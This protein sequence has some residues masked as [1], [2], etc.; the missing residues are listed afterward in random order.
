MSGKNR[1]PHVGFHMPADLRKLMRQVADEQEITVTELMIR[2][3]R[4]YLLN[5]GKIKQ[6]DLK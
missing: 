5:V 3:V 2:A 4:L 1:H 6:G